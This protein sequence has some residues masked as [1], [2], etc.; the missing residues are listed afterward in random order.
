[1]ED[2]EEKVRWYGYHVTSCTGATMPAMYGYID[3]L[4]WWLLADK[5]GKVDKPLSQ[6]DIA[7]GW[8]SRRGELKTVIWLHENYALNDVSNFAMD[9]AARNGHLETFKWLHKNRTEGCSGQAVVDAKEN[10][11]HE[12]V[13][14]MRENGLTQGCG[15]YRTLLRDA[16][17]AVR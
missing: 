6:L 12:I 15:K 8:A 3:L 10:N 4:K 2:L 9:E 13:E 5:Y 16:A 11:H 17:V 14:Y 1:M 7:F